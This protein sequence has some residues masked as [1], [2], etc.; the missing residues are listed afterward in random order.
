MEAG[1][2]MEI[3][4]SVGILKTNRVFTLL[5]NKKLSKSK[6]STKILIVIHNKGYFKIWGLYQNAN[7]NSVVSKDR[8][9]RS[10]YTGVPV[11]ITALR[12]R[13]K[14]LWWNC[15]YDPYYKIF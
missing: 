10:A 6:N 13:N 11:L 3:F 9:V 14:S 12:Y 7:E 8:R 2:I 5:F 15:R 1:N 4:P